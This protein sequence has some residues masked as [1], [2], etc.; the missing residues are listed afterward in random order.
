MIYT[1]LDSPLGALLIAGRDG[2]VTFIGLPEGRSAVQPASSW[3]RDDGEWAAARRQLAAYFGGALTEFDLALRPEGTAFQ[4]QV[5]RALRQIPYGETRSYAQLAASIGRPAAVRA[6]GRA[7]GSNP[8]AI[9]IP[10]HRVI[11]SNGTLTGYGGGLTAKQ[12]LLDLERRNGRLW[13]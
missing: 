5:W 3:R 2:A 11:G 12:W 6:V 7:N 9:V 10:C 13:S 4:Q 1:Y 8:L